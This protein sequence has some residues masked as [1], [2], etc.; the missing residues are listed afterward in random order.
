MFAKIR[1]FNSFDSTLQ[2]EHE[3]KFSSNKELLSP[4]L[5][6]VKLVVDGFV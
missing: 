5:R 1:K 4:F 3:A 6:I 2:E